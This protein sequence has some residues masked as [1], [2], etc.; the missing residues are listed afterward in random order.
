MGRIVVVG[1]GVAGLS[2]ARA[3][4][5]MGFTV[6][7]IEARRLGSEAGSSMGW[8][9]IF[10]FSYEDQ[11]YS[12]LMIESE[13]CW[14]EIEKESQRK[15]IEYCPALNITRNPSDL[16]A[17]QCSLESSGR[18]FK[19]L[20]P[21]DARLGDFGIRLLDDEVGVLEVDAGIMRPQATLSALSQVARQAGARILEGV[22]ATK[23]YGMK[24]SIRVEAGSHCF[25]ADRV[26]V[27]AGP[28]AEDLIHDLNP[29]LNVTRQYQT[30]FATT[31][32]V[33]VGPCLSWA[34]IDNDD[35]YGILNGPDGLHMIG[36]HK[37]GEKTHPDSPVEIEAVDRA[38]CQQLSFMRSHLGTDVEFRPLTRRVCHYTNTANGDF[39]IESLPD[40]PEIVILSACSGHGFKFG[41]ITGRHAVQVAV[42]SAL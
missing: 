42:S 24:S 25:D 41:V 37:P 1:A 10:R 8:A 38:M 30:M 40:F 35:L 11:R 36:S 22:K 16:K 3:A 7:C 2:A 18:S 28:W 33:G 17:L 12:H 21:D 5:S 27:A 26:I 32:P 23:I 20:H 34:N 9:K 19:V 4:A 13:R 31:R 29:R 6:T 39:L 15:L 14:G